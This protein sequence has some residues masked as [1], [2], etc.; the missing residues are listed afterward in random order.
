MM[1]S[2]ARRLLLSLL[3]ISCA[4]GFAAGDATTCTC[5]S[6][7]QLLSQALSPCGAPSAGLATEPD[8]AVQ[9]GD[10]T[11]ARQEMLGFGAAW[12]DATVEAFDSLPVDAQESV[13]QELFANGT[14]GGIGLRLLRHTAGQSDLTPADIGAWSYDETDGDAQLQDFS[15]GAPGEKMVQWLV[16]MNAATGGDNV[17][18]L[19]SLWSPPLWMKHPVSNQL[20]EQYYDAYTSYIVKYVAAFRAAGVTVD[21]VTLQNEPLHG[22]GDHHWTMFLLP[23]LAATLSAAVRSKLDA[24]GLSATKIWAFDHNTN[25]P[26]YPQYVLDVRKKKE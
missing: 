15:L 14:E 8:W 9:I 3:L 7:N 18:L 16:R 22:E 23:E 21:A 4:G 12:T 10:V 1:P 19:G 17:T 13:L 2:A 25:T 24:A 11:G 5:T 20:L 6:T 26:E